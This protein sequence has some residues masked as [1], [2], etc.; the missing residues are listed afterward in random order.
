MGG[1]PGSGFIKGGQRGGQ[2][3]GRGLGGQRGGIQPSG[4]GPQQQFYNNQRRPFRNKK[5]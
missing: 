5:K 1:G 2:R 3:G 4:P